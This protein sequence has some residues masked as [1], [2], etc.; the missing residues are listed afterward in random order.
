[1]FLSLVYSGIRSKTVDGNAYGGP[2]R[3]EGIYVFHGMEIR[4]IRIRKRCCIFDS[5][6]AN[7]PNMRQ[8]TSQGDL[9]CRA[10]PVL[11]KFA[12]VQYVNTPSFKP[13]MDTTAMKIDDRLVSDLCVGS[14]LGGG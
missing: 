12:M 8:N 10:G 6:V 13:L 9:S 4:P 11:F 7:L 2:W 5:S 3:G 1:M 14:D